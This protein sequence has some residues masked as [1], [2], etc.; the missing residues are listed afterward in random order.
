MDAGF[1]FAVALAFVFA[2]TNG[3]HDASNAI[4]TLVATRAARPLQAVVMASVFNVLGPL[5]VGSAV[6]DTIGGIVTLAPDEAIQVIGAGLA[7]AVTWNVITWWRGLPSSSGHALVG[8]LVGAG[9]LEGGVDAIRWGGLDGWHPVGVFGT[10]IALAISPAVGLLVALFAVRLLRSIGRR[11]TRRWRAPVRAGQWGTAAALAF[12]HGANDAQ[13]AAG[14]VAALLLAEGHIGH[15]APPLWVELGSALA[16]TLGTAFGGWRIV[17][18]V[19]RR[20]YRIRPLDGLASSGAAAGVILGA[21]LVGGP[22]STTQVVASSVVG[23][24]GGRRRWHHVHWAI[25]RHMGLA[26]LITIPATAALAAVAL[27]VWRWLA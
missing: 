11:A 14:I 23:I 13:K 9:V 26:W 22:V 7:A 24:G 21:S 1:G 27:V 10:L 17:K 8:G 6:A 16:L 20:I 15:L 25:V 5:V 3:F 2:L 12:S 18:T 19:G 4:A